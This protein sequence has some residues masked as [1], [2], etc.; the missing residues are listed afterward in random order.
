MEDLKELEEIIGR[1]VK[2]KR[3]ELGLSIS[4]VAKAS[5]VSRYSVRQLESGKHNSRLNIFAA[6]AEALG[7]SG[8][9][10]FKK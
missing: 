9:E 5:G 2:A 10:L 4:E 3:L 1:N 6:I 8:P 7:M